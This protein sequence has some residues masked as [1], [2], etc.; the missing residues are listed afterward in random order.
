MECLHLCKQYIKKIFRTVCDRVVDQ[1]PDPDGRYPGSD[2][3]PRHTCVLV[4][5]Q[6]LSIILTTYRLYYFIYAF[7][8]LTLSVLLFID[9]TR[10][11]DVT[12]V[13]YLQP[14]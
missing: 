12:C 11:I 2:G 1:F 4:I 5:K 3:A 13:V 9:V 14:K 6:T 10:T 8:P 7:S